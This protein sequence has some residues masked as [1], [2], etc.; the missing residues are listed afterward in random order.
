MWLFSKK[1][2]ETEVLKQEII[3][4]KEENSKLVKDNESLKSLIKDFEH[5]TSCRDRFETIFNYENDNLKIG[6]SDIQ[7]NV[8]S[9][10]GSAKGI[11]KNVHVLFN[12]FGVLITSMDVIA[13]NLANL[14]HL[15]NH[16][17]ENVNN[18]SSRASEIDSIL[19]LIKDIA[20]QTNLLA[21]N[22]AIEAARAGEHGRGF[23]VVADEVRKLADRT[24]KAI[25][26]IY[27]VVQ[28]MQQDVVEVD[29]DA[30]KTK[31][32]IGEIDENV[33]K[34]IGDLKGI[35]SEIQNSFTDVDRVADYVFMSLAKLDH[36][37][38]KL[39]TYM[40][41]AK[42]K[43]IFEFVN[44][45]NCRLGKW[46]YE[47]DG[48]E[49]FS[50]SNAYKELE[51]PHSVVHNGTKHVFELLD[52]FDF[53]EAGFDKL[54]KALSEMEEGSKKVFASLDKMLQEKV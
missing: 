53:S 10:V 5:S 21:L 28:S 40:S 47:G 38:W 9:A 4:L 7:S 36:I 20:E 13:Q 2:D 27:V 8:S 6:L 14:T 17:S 44:H 50:R 37:I 11:I 43:P 31:D 26:E 25:G 19:S 3:K 35:N 49:Y 34:F 54:M 52:N 41:V 12:D 15:A 33:S 45:H 16:T 51:N 42:H 18:L 24:Q 23:A 22:A 1:N 32:S 46:Y 29:K 39:N 30:E 48:K